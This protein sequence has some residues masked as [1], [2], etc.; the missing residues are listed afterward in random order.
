[1]RRNGNGATATHS[2]TQSAG[3][4]PSHVQFGFFQLFS[5]RSISWWV[6]DAQNTLNR[7]RS[8]GETC[9]FNLNLYIF[10]PLTA[11]YSHTFELYTRLSCMTLCR[12][13]SRCWRRQRTTTATVTATRWNEKK[14]RRKAI[15]CSATTGTTTTT[16]PKIPSKAIFKCECVGKCACGRC[17][18]LLWNLFIYYENYDKKNL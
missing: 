17:L 8:H 9:K 12:R 16:R 6:P 4:E 10:F 7:W 1:M 2:L 14:T 18:W 13:F 3:V 15:I 5:G 11:S